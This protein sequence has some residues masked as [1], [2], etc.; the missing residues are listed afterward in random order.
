M[1]KPFPYKDS[2][3]VPWKYNVTLISSRIGKE[4]VCLNISSGLVGLTKSGRCYTLEELE[5]MRKEIGKGIAKPVWNRVTTK[6]AEEY[7]K[8]IQKVD[9]SV[10]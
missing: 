5:K 2:H 4:E 3:R 1:P 10:I 8:T 9:Y 6:E 7:L